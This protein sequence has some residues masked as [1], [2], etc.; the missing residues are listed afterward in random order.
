MAFSD[1]TLISRRLFT[2]FALGA[3][4]TLL[5]AGCDASDDASDVDGAVDSSEAAEEVTTTVTV[6]DRDAETEPEPEQDPNTISIVM[7][8]D[9]LVHPSVW[10]S[11]ELEDGTRNY[12]HLF[13][14][15]ADVVE[16][17]SLAILVQETILGDEDLG[18]SGFP[19]FCSPQ[20][21]GDAEVEAGFDV[22]VHATN[23]SIDQG[24]IGIETELAYWR[25]SHP[26]MTVVGIADSEEVAAE[27][28]VLEVGEHSVCVLSYTRSLNGLELPDDAPWAVRM[29]DEDQIASDI[30]LARDQGA[31]LVIVCPHW[32]TEY[33]HEPNDYQTTWAQTIADLGADV[34]IGSHTHALQP[35][36]TIESSDGRTVPL[37]WSLGNFVS[38]QSREITMVGGMARLTVTFNDDGSFT[39]ASIGLS[40]VVTHKAEGTNFTTY[41]LADYT[42]ELAASNLI[43]E[44]DTEDCT[45]F[46]RAWC[47]DECADCLGDGFDAETCE[48]VLSI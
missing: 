7:V 32:G 33:T 11:G 18:F 48:Y 27:V 44:S 22:A 8:G 17:A 38:G 14:Q 4:S 19:T 31:E 10:E 3:A 36:T 13:A 46:T 1:K 30:Q 12:D 40:P 25:N 5:L 20:E 9:I 45:G 47:V 39:F 21:I 16:D 24:L 6:Y 28:P 29:I 37:Y 35:V 43:L 34:I 15:V 26:E 42:E 23:H 2:R 41:F